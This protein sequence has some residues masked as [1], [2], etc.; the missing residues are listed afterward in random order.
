MKTILDYYGC[1]KFNGNAKVDP[2]VINFY[3]YV[4]KNLT[5]LCKQQYSQHVVERAVETMPR[6]YLEKL[7]AAIKNNSS[8]KHKVF[9]EIM[10]DQYGNFI[11]KT[12]IEK[13]KQHGL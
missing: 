13:A 10:F 3:D 7:C 1:S 8:K 11:A 9:K 2:L 5:V 4:I 6:E 12:L